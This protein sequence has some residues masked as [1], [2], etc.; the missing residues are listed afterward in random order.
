MSNRIISLSLIAFVCVGCV[1]RN[2]STR[3]QP[4]SRVAVS[5]MIVAWD[6]SFVD[7]FNWPTDPPVLNDI[8]T[9]F[10]FA[11]PSGTRST[12][13]EFAASET[14]RLTDTFG[15]RRNDEYVFVT[16]EALS[17]S[18]RLTISSAKGSEIK[19]HNDVTVELPKFGSTI[20]K[21]ANAPEGGRYTYLWVIARQ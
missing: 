3:E 18:T 9:F 15:D 11:R 10:L 19:L 6:S 20:I 1:K 2:Y 21:T 8:E 14:A 5:C 7:S 17:E 13:I 16:G 12:P 4:A